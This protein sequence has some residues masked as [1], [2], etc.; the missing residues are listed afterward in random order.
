MAKKVALVI[1][2]GFGIN[3]KTPEEN[4][5]KRANH[6]VFTDLFSKKHAQ[7]QASW[8]SVGLPAWQMWN[9]EVG[10]ITLWTWRVV[11]QSFV[12]INKLFDNH[13][14]E[15][16]PNFIALLNHC[17]ENH[18]NLHLL[19]I[20]GKGGVHSC[21]EHL[22]KLLPLIPSDQETYI[23]FFWDGRDLP[24]QSAYELMLEFEE[25]LKKYPNIHI[26]SFGWRYF[27][28]DRDN[29]WDRVQKAYDQIIYRKD[30]VSG[31]VADYIKSCYDKWEKDEFIT[32]ISFEGWKWIAPND[33]VLYINFRTDRARQFTQALLVSS[34]PEH[35]EKIPL[36]NKDFNKTDLKGLKL[37]TM[38]KYY[39]DYVGT[40]I[41]PEKDVKNT[42]SEVLSQHGLKQFHL[43]E[44]EKFAHVTKFFNAENSKVYEGQENL[45]VPSHKVATYDLDP[46][47]SAEEIYDNF[48]KRA[49]D[50]D[51]FIINYANGDMVGHT[52]IMPA[53]ITAINTLWNVVEKMLKLSKDHDID[54]LLTADHGNCEEMGT[55][56]NP[57]TAHTTNL[58]PCWHISKWEVIDDVVD[59]WALYDLAPSIL[60]L[61]GINK[62]EEMTGNSLIK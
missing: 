52:G 42:L 39:P 36:W 16:H 38:T 28:M 29:N 4:G 31:S 59:S 10:H 47:M 55:P 12:T 48:E 49:E 25:E 35:A 6:P 41:L 50:F 23:H 22:T 27:G 40:T 5:I 46:A 2:D 9:S 13:E 43:A 53:V 57:K 7:L 60:H 61:L 44:T 45:L 17:K 32:P 30:V 20:F 33:W 1:L 14:F 26:A 15:K 51:V 11:E 21:D 58:V 19:Q 54:I 62:P 34:M 18:S 37:V 24:P 3:D 8:E 56:E